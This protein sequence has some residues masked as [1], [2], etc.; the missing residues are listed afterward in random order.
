ME[1]ADVPVG[2]VKLAGNQMPA[3]NAPSLVAAD[4]GPHNDTHVMRGC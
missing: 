3:T 4:Q 1:A 2:A